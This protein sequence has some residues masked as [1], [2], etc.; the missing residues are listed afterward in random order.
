MKIN[1]FEKYFKNITALFNSTL[2]ICQLHGNARREKFN[3]LLIANYK[4]HKFLAC[5][6]LII[7]PLYMFYPVK[8]FVIDG[9]LVP[10]VPIEFMFVDQSAKLG[11]FIASAVMMTGGLYATFGTE[12]IV[13][14]FVVVVMNYAVRVDILEENFHELDELWRDTST[15]TLTYRHL[16]LRNICRKY[17]DMRE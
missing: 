5:I 7:I 10:F 4:F 15:S 3:N 17:I 1:C 2:K 11:F 13:L 14:A 6:A 8:S 16:F 9:K 12:Y